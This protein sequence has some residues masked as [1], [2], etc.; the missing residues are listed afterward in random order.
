MPLKVLS[1]GA[2]S[3]SSR[4]PH[5]S[6][7]E[8]IQE[9]IS[10]KPGFLIRYGIAISSLVLVLILFACW[11]IKYPDIINT[12]AKL[13]SL[14][15]PKVVI[16]K[17]DGKLIALNIKEGDHVEENEILGY[18]ESIA[19]PEQVLKLSIALDSISSLIAHNKTEAIP[20]Y[21]A[22]FDFENLGELQ[23]SFQT[24]IQAFIT[25][26][27]YLRDGFYV[28]KKTM[29]NTDLTDLQRMHYNLASQETLQ[30][31]DESLAQK[32]Y[33]MN[34]ILLKE[35]V[36][37]VKEF[38][39][40]RSK[41]LNK[42]MSVPQLKASIIFNESQQNDKKKEILEL[43]NVTAQQKDV[44]VQTLNTLTSRIEDWEKKYLLIS[45]VTGKLYFN[46]F[47]QK[48]QQM[49]TGEVICYINPGNSSYY[50]EMLIPQHNFGKVK[51][52]QE[53]LLQFP[54]YPY[55]EF[56]EIKGR[57]DFISNIP[58]DS[59]YLAKVIFPDGLVTTYKK[60]IIYRDGLKANAEIIIENM[61]L[62]E[63]F[64]NNLKVQ[65]QR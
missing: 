42:S 24:F 57:I 59:G 23:E 12:K 58:S 48:N 41:L 29:L 35:K 7:S 15:A 20:A 22:A 43:E 4:S 36:I 51:T 52:G 30:L 44:F 11:L 28:R 25:Y 47:I 3:S 32:T 6:R 33:E 13:T 14:N 54:A 9:I 64:Y 61:R 63:R 45:P 17:T 55:T 65:I 31:E 56:G 27:D 26:K 53:V 21:I 8:A 10:K 2:M 1:N 19:R 40:E 18:L 16:S 49:K 50:A 39:D 37:S 5:P 46:S 60:Q 34:E 62:L 38:R